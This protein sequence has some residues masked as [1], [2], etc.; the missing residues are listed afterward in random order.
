[1]T[2]SSTPV[3]LITGAARRIGA[4]I[5]RHLHARGLNLMLHYRQSAAEA[6]MLADDLNR[7][8]PGSAATHQADLL[9]CGQL[10][11]LVDAT[12][13]QFGRLDYLVNNASSFFPTP[14]GRIDEASW[15]DLI[16]SN[17]KAPL[18]LA[19]AAAPH[20]QQA[21]GAIVGIVD[22]H[23][24]RPMPDHAV[25]SAAKAGHAAVLRTLARDLAPQVRVNGVAPGANLWPENGSL[26]D[27]SSRQAIEASIPLGRI[28][29]PDDIA[30]AVGFL[31]LDA[32]YITGHVLPVDGGRSIVL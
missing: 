32:H 2:P 19:Q 7:L 22:I 5:A 29:T 23:I 26:F 9:D 3:V 21:N 6:S 30:V 13:K 25:Y 27:T 16:G 24:D 18:W 4:G 11:A 31:L 28:G 17:L 8:R 20:L 14:V 1:M 12:L 15:A 10:P